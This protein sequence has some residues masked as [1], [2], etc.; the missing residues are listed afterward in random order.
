MEELL[1]PASAP[2]APPPHSGPGAPWRAMAPR[3]GTW[4]TTLSVL[5]H[6]HLCLRLPGQP[7]LRRKTHLGETWARQDSCPTSR[8]WSS[9]PTVPP[10]NPLSP[11]SQASL[12]YFL[13]R[14]VPPG[15]SPSPSCGSATI[16]LNF[17][18]R[19][20]DKPSPLLPAQE[21]GDDAAGPN[22]PRGGTVLSSCGRSCC[23][24]RG[25]RGVQ[26]EEPAP[27]AARRQLHPPTS[28]ATCGSDFAPHL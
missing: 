2:G 27:W 15:T 17:S 16:S 13:Q 20:T 14:A 25:G 21:G 7:F 22:R 10:L 9:R 4:T 19:G 1:A 5:P 28:S 11:K 6:Q 26:R 23:D 8:G 18:F 24:P 3:T 12:V